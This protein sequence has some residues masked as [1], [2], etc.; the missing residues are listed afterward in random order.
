MNNHILR[1]TG[2]SELSEPLDIETDYQILLDCEVTSISKRGNNDGNFSFVYSARQKTAEI[3]DKRGKTIKADRKGQSAKLRGQIVNLA[4]EQ[5]KDP[6][7]EYERV[8]IK[9]RHFLPDILKYIDG[10]EGNL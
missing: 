7:V 2:S 8:M 5:G 3:K 10:L 9:L 4:L 1:I 6:D